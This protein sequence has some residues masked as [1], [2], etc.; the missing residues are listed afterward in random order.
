MLLFGATLAALRKKHGNTSY[1]PVSQEVEAFSHTISTY[2]KQYGIPEYVELI[3]AVMMRKSGG[4]GSDPMQCSESEYNTRFPREPNW[5]ADLEYSVEVGVQTL[6]EVLIM[7]QVQIPI[8]LDGIS[9]AIQ[10]YNYGV[11]YISWALSYSV[12]YT[13]LNAFEYSD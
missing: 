11:G 1:T 10:G 3:K 4:Q 6:A 12:G 5:I 2:A 9:L 8:D 7:A 13:E